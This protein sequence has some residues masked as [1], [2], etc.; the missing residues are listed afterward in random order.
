MVVYSCINDP[1]CTRSYGRWEP[2]APTSCH[3]PYSAHHPIPRLVVRAEMRKNVGHPNDPP[4]CQVDG[5][6]SNLLLVD[7]ECAQKLENTQRRETPQTT[8]AGPSNLRRVWGLER[9]WLM[10]LPCLMRL[11]W[12]MRLRSRHCAQWSTRSD[13]MRSTR[14]D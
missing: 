7:R 6:C 3:H 1:R 4:R 9:P 10:R 5:I 14:M 2:A 12:L 13:I 8:V 11:P